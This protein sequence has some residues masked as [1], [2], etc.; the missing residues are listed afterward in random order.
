MGGT[1]KDLGGVPRTLVETVGYGKILYF[2]IK[3]KSL[4]R[5]LSLFKAWGKFWYRIMS[6]PTPLRS[7]HEKMVLCRVKRRK[8][9]N[10]GR[11]RPVA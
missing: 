3:K 4:I 10:V 11:R 9:F 5:L 2:L 7:S 6:G 1:T 8:K